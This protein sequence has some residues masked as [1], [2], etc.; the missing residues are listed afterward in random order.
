MYTKFLLYSPKCTL[1]V[2]LYLNQH[3]ECISFLIKHLQR[4]FVE[5]L[6]SSIV[7]VHIVFPA[8]FVFPASAGPSVRFL[9]PS[10]SQWIN[11]KSSPTRT[12]TCM[13]VLMRMQETNK[14]G[15]HSFSCWIAAAVRQTSCSPVNRREHFIYLFI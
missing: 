13:C 10:V 3:V 14:T 2:S 5:H 8:A 7:Y 6:N 11:V 15:T 12:Y 9:P 4:H 1:C